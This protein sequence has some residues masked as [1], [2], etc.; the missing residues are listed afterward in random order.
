[1]LAFLQA[2]DNFF[3]P[4]FSSFAAFLARFRTARPAKSVMASARLLAA[5]PCPPVNL[6]VSLSSRQKPAA[7][8]GQKAYRAEGR[9]PVPS[10]GIPHSRS[11]VLS[12]RR[13]TS[14]RPISVPHWPLRLACGRKRCGTQAMTAALGPCQRPAAGISAAPEPVPLQSAAQRQAM[15]VPALGETSASSVLA[16]LMFGRMRRRLSASR[17]RKSLIPVKE[18]DRRLRDN[19]SAAPFRKSPR[20]Q[21]W[22]P[23]PPRQS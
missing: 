2:P 1:M 6:A 13:R 23:K 17:P 20:R 7:R 15:A 21:A 3:Q 12:A 14:Q 9:F 16:L 11:L 10:L 22:R 4:S 18:T 8:I 5:L 19:A